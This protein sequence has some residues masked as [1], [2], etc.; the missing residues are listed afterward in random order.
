MVI[1]IVGLGLNYY[2]KDGFNI[3]DC[4]IVLISL[5]EIVLDTTNITTTNGKS[6]VLALRAFRLL[7][8]F[9]LAQSWR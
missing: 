3:F 2:F 6:A 5:I 4:V 8:V 7:R 9:K 1:K